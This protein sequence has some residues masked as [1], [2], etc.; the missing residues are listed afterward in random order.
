MM[1]SWVDKSMN[2]VPLMYSCSQASYIITENV[3]KLGLDVGGD[4]AC[5]RPSVFADLKNPS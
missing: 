2:V 3:P 4:L 5:S 1:K